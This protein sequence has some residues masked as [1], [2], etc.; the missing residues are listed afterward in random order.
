[1]EEEEQLRVTVQ[2]ARNFRR[3]FFRPAEE[4]AVNTMRAPVLGVDAPVAP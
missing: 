4:L 2:L 1:M 3:P